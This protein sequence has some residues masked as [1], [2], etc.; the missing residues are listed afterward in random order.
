MPFLVFKF[1]TFDFASS[2]A[3]SLPPIPLWNQ[4]SNSELQA[5]ETFVLMLGYIL[6]VV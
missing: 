1:M 6:V 3:T 5:C 4:S 2:Y